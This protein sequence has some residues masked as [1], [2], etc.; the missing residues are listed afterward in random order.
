MIEPKVKDLLRVILDKAE[1]KPVNNDRYEA[2][3]QGL[4][5]YTS[6]KVQ[7]KEEAVRLL[8]ERKF[9]RDIINDFGS[10]EQKAVIKGMVAKALPTMRIVE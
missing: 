9:N 7:E 1:G 6:A 3:K 2:C 8:E 5:F 4:R 10:E